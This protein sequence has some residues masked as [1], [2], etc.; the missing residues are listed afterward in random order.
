MDGLAVPE[1]TKL[2][3]YKETA[4]TI[5][6]QKD[7]EMEGIE[8]AMEQ[9]LVLQRGL[10]RKR[11]RADVSPSTIWWMVKAESTMQSMITA[12][13]ESPTKRVKVPELRQAQTE[14]IPYA[15]K[16]S[17]RL[18]A[19]IRSI[20]NK[21]FT[22]LIKHNTTKNE[23]TKYRVDLEKALRSASGFITAALLNVS[24]SDPPDLTHEDPSL[25]KNY[26]T[27]I[28]TG[29]IAAPKQTPYSGYKEGMAPTMEHLAQCYGLGER[30][31][32]VKYRN[33]ILCKILYHVATKRLFPG[34]RA[35][36]IIYENT[37]RGSPARK[38]M[39]DFWAYEGSEDWLK[40]GSIRSTIHL[41][42]LE[43][44]VPALLRLREKPVGK[45]WPWVESGRAYLIG[46]A[47]TRVGGTFAAKEDAMAM[48]E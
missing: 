40:S 1:W 18:N 28:N 30:L 33:A 27:W 41:E 11:S 48:Q 45:S 9:K 21:T 24:F 15:V 3:Q 39:V 47:G 5:S 19:H 26:L 44:L 17:L 10:R 32:D 8:V 16:S 4:A 13:D 25:V 22:V 7:V 2:P 14:Q 42:F 37:T 20:F 12:T 6:E 31:Q 34:D 29:N 38:L 43:D 46:E 36:A 23:R 35:V